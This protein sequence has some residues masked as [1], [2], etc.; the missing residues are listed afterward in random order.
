MRH[1]DL[2]IVMV[3]CGVSLEY[4]LIKGKAEDNDLWHLIL[5]EDLII[6]MIKAEGTLSLEQPLSTISK[7]G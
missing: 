7:S 5:H 3:G 1:S 6:M 4:N 2:I